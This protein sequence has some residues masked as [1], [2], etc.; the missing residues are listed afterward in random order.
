MTIKFTINI[1]FFYFKFIKKKSQM[2]DQ[3]I[4]D[5]EFLEDVLNNTNFND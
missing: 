3:V 4:I 1:R 2:D 5:M